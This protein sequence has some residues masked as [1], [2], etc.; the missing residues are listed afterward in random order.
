M[1]YVMY[2]IELTGFHVLGVNTWY[3]NATSMLYGF[4]VI[5][6]LTTNLLTER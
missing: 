5:I 4:M 3:T 6:K 1:Y 2:I